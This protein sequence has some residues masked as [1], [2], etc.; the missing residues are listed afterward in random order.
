MVT[1]MPQTDPDVIFINYRRTE[2]AWPADRLATGLQRVFGEDR[3]FLDARGIAAGDEFPSV[4]EENLRRATVLIVLISK[5]WLHVHDEYGR[6]RLDLDDDWVR[7]EIRTGLE[8]QDCRV[9][10]VLIDDAELPDDKAV[11]PVDIADLVRRQWIPIRQAHSDDDIEILCRRLESAGFQRLPDSDSSGDQ[12]FDDSKVNDVVERVTAT[13]PLTVSVLIHEANRLFNRM[14]FRYEPTYRCPGQN[15]GQRLHAALQT[16]KV[17][18]DYQPFVE[19]HA[20]EHSQTYESL[21]REVYRYCDY[22]L[23]F[24]FESPEGLNPLRSVVGNEEAFRQA[25]PTPKHFEDLEK[26]ADVRTADEPRDLAIKH[27]DEL[28]KAFP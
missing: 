22:M 5:G 23:A 17:L 16:W 28:L 4:I 7:R 12:E 13:E 14:T 15:W 6:R 26:D 10:P 2:S 27:M 24:L 25:L 11:L 9:I 3:V 18:E 8:R 21:V 1:R 20:K 19:E